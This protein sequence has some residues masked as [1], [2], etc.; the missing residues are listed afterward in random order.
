MVVM[1]QGDYECEGVVDIEGE[2][3]STLANLDESKFKLKK[4]EDKIAHL[5]KFLDE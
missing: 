4:V 5:R 1:E 2:L 3:R